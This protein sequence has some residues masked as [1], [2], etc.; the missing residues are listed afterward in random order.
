VRI[1]VPPFPFDD[2][3]RFASG[4]K[5]AV[6]LFKTPSR[7]GIHI[8]DVKLVNGEDSSPARRASC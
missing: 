7:D 8:E 2:P 4:S 3:K 6:I 5:D 1:V